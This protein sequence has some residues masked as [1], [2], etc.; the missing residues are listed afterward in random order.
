MDPTIIV[1]VIGAV[2]TLIGALFGYRSARMQSRGELHRLREELAGSDKA[3]QDQAHQALLAANEHRVRAWQRDVG[4]APTPDLLDAETA[5]DNA[6]AAVI[7]HGTEKTR[8][9]AEAMRA[10]WAGAAGLDIAGLEMLY[11][12]RGAL[13]ETVSEDADAARRMRAE[14]ER[15]A[16]P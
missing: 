12:L 8:A 4:R 11:R 1:A 10:A 16:N 13:L 15:T 14:I 5:F 2:A 3:K 9:A 7:V 6:Y